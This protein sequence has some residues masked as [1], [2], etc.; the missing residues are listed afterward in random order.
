M[1]HQNHEV[2]FHRASLH[3][4]HSEARYAASDPPSKTTPH[5]D[6]SGG[7]RGGRGG[8][9]LEAGKPPPTPLPSEPIRLAYALASSFLSSASTS[10]MRISSALLTAGVRKWP[11]CQNCAAHWRI[12]SAV[13]G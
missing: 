2:R 5:N 11:A 7:G 13:V 12:A 4:A 3:R 6:T 9:V 10:A 8:G 1:H